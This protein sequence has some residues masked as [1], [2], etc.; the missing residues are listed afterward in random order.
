MFTDQWKEE[1]PVKHKGLPTL[2]EIEPLFTGE[3]YRVCGSL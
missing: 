3:K 1:M 2:P